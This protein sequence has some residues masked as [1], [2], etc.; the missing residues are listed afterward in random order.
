M[1]QNQSVL[2]K[3]KD[4]IDIKF[5]VPLLDKIPLVSTGRSAIHKRVKWRFLRYCNK[6][7]Y[8]TVPEE[9]ADSYTYF[10]PDD[11][12]YYLM[13]S[14]YTPSA[15]YKEWPSIYHHNLD[16][17]RFN[18]TSYTGV[19]LPGDWDLYKKPYEFDLVYKAVKRYCTE[20]ES[21]DSSEYMY[22]R[23][24]QEIVQDKDG[25]VEERKEVI[26]TL[27]ENM[28]EDGFLTQYELGEKRDG[29]P[30][31]TESTTG[32]EIVVNIGRNGEIIFNN[33][34]HHRLAMSKLLDIDEIPVIVVV[35]HKQWEEIRNQIRS[36]D[37][38]EQLDDKI[39]KYLDHPDVKD[40][41]PS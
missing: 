9:K 12:D 31:Y 17:G 40:I 11:I 27:H 4:L 38:Y 29:E 19:I 34:A 15:F 35:R 25:H 16:K 26:Q 37:T 30:V 10:D 18:P 21:L 8:D 5:Y 39:R 2:Q 28:I 13:D 32:W 20:D 7:R 23:F 3:A 6:L 33:S 1:T 41:I 14:D 22:D 36:A 24:L